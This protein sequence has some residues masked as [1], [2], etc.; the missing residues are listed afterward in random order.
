AD[1][2]FMDSGD[3]LFSWNP[4]DDTDFVEGGDNVDTVQVIGGGGAE[5]FSVVANG[6]RV[7]FDRLSPLPFSLD[8]GTVEN[9]VLEARGGDDTFGCAGNLA[10]LISLTIDGGEGNDEILGSNGADLIFGGPGT[11][12]LSGREGLDTVFGG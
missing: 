1:V 11:D 4:G 2:I 3:D 6:T 9:L 7:R 8:I 5:S 12:T 10:A